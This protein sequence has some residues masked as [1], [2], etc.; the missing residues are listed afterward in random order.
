MGR[1][2]TCW[3][4]V[5]TTGPIVATQGRLVDFDPHPLFADFQMPSE[6]DIVGLERE[7]Q[8]QLQTPERIRLNLLGFGEI[9]IAVAYPT[10]APRWACKRMPPAASEADALRFADYIERYMRRLHEAKVKCIPT[11]FY[12]VRSSNGLFAL[13]LCQ[14]ILA[15]GQLG[16]VVMKSRT[17]DEN[18]EILTA[19][20][21]ALRRGTSPDLG[22]D[23]QLANWAWID[24]EPWLLDVSTPF[25]REPDGSIELDLRLLTEPYPGV[26]RPILRRWI[27]PPM[28]VRYL[29]L[30]NTLVDFVSYLQKERLDHWLEAAVSAANRYADKPLTVQEMRN[31]YE[32]DAKLWE[33]VYRTKVLEKNMCRWLGRTYQYL[34]PPPMDRGT[35]RPT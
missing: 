23:P 7:V 15:Q 8:A 20:L 12:A 19:I 2:R 6:A 28:I 10:E 25:M 29:E 22:I 35:I 30:R 32:G 11:A 26:L 16:P 17:P 31:Y 14:P 33:F 27:A 13:Y 3:E 21:E 1:M 5:V 18:D 34:L 24:G 9:T 4:S